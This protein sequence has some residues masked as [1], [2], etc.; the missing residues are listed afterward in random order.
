[1]L[2]KRAVTKSCPNTVWYCF[3]V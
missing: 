1:M 2:S 3:A